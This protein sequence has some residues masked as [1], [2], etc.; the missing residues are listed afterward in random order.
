LP[1]IDRQRKKRP[2]GTAFDAILTRIDKS[3]PQGGQNFGLD[4]KYPAMSNCAFIF[5]PNQGYTS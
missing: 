5:A 4:M 3:Y 1:I 2:D